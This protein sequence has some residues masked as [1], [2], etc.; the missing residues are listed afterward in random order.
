[1]S[2]IQEVGVW[3]S[4]PRWA[5]S[6]RGRVRRVGLMT[7]SLLCLLGV[8]D[9]LAAASSIPLWTEGTENSAVLPALDQLNDALMTMTQRL[10]PAVVSLRVSRD[11]ASAEL[12][13][14]HPALPQDTPMYGTGSGFIIRSDGLILTNHHVVEGGTSIEILFY[15]GDQHVAK[16]L[17]VDPLGDLAL[18]R[19]ATETPLPVAPLGHSAALR[20]GEFVVAI[21]SP[22]GFE[23]TVTFGIVSGTRRHLLHSGVVG[24]FIQTDA[25]IHTGNSGGPLVNMRG[26]VVGVNTATVGRGELGFAIPIDAVKTV[27]PMLYHGIAPERGWLGVQIRPLDADKAQTLG[28]TAQ[29]GV[30]VH[31]VL[32]DQPAQRAGIQVGDVIT[33][34]DG[35]TVSN[36][37]DLQRVVS[38]TPVGKTVQV[39]VYRK[40]TVHRVELTVGAMPPQESK[41]SPTR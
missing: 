35:T 34:F 37:F 5:W 38:A 6:L 16:V 25:S 29:R 2:K 3:C 28:L 20:V 30:Y 41:V 26:E 40:R 8:D 31:D 39:E 24:G 1:M 15:N 14:N 18:L 27:L 23:H 11:A 33:G 32:Q 21:G 7:I 4:I 19:I 12:P 22:F 10:L 36:P 17:G 9:S 13:K